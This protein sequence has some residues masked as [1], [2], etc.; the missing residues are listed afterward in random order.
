MDLSKPLPVDNGVTFQ[1]R[2]E[3]LDKNLKLESGDLTPTQIA[4]FKR[5]FI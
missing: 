5:Y 1:E 4:G 2:V 3:F